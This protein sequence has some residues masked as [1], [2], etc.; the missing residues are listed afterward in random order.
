MTMSFT[1]GELAAQ[2]G[3]TIDETKAF[4]SMFSLP[5]G[6]APTPGR[7][8]DIEDVRNHP[9][10]R[11]DAGHHLCVSLPSLLFALRGRIENALKDQGPKTFSRYERH[12][13]KVVERRA[14]AALEK[15]LRPDW[16]HE[17]LL[18]DVEEDGV[19]KRPEL[20][21][22]VRADSALVIVES[23]ASSMRPSAKRLAPD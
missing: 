15:A 4:L 21:G 18:Y 20:D 10:I 3:C 6:E 11:D 16:T 22:L 5:F 19:A 23:K 13:S 8:I 17:G 1:P 14:V 7:E 9:L 2:T 12:R